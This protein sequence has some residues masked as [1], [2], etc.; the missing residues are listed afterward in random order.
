MVLKEP[1]PKEYVGSGKDIWAPSH[2]KPWSKLSSVLIL[3]T[4]AD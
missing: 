1:S 2:K 4:E 3:H